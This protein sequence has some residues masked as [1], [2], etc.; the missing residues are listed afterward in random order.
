MMR[1]DLLANR[2]NAIREGAPVPKVENVDKAI[3]EAIKSKKKLSAEI[4]D[5]ESELSAAKLGVYRELKSLAGVIAAS[6]LYGYAANGVAGL[7]LEFIEILGLGALCNSVLTF[8]KTVVS[9][10]VNKFT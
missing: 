8:T 5:K 2:L 10:I 7:E 9:K 4:K 1:D 6:L 3:S